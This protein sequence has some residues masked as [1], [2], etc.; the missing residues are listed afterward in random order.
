MTLGEV[1]VIGAL[2][3]IVGVWLGVSLAVWQHK[4]RRK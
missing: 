4:R 2:V 1:L 3:Q